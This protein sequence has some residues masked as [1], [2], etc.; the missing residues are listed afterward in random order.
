[1][2][3]AAIALFACLLAI[4][5][6][7]QTPL[8]AVELPTF[9]FAG[10][11]YNQYSGWSGVVS[12]IIP[13]SNKF[14][15]YASFTGDLSA[16]QY[17]APS[18]GKTGYLLSPSFRAGQHKVLWGK[19]PGAKTMLLVGGDLGASFTQPPPAPGL[20][21]DTT[22]ASSTVS[23]NLAGS[24]TLTLVRQLSPHLAVAAP[25]RML[26]ISGV[27]PN[28]TGAWNPVVELGIVWKP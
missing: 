4:T 16:V 9:I 7:A 20:G 28:G 15:M 21:T 3:Y 19:Q 18:T 1:M 24:F 13:E 10:A 22:P 2:K 5:G 8:D 12:G 6:Q 26:W 11:S 27:G 17:T 14:G 25:V 23:V